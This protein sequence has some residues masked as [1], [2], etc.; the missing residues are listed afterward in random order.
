M[1]R[2]LS[3][4]LPV[5]TARRREDFFVSSANQRAVA[6]IDTW[7]DW[8]SGKIVLAGPPGSGKTHL[9]HIWADM[10]EG[11]IVAA[12]DLSSADIST[13]AAT[14]VAVEDC[15]SIAGD[16]DAERALF[17]LHNLTL[18]EGNPILFTARTA[19]T[20]WS[21]VLPDLASRMQATT[22]VMLEPPDDALLTAVLAK[23]FDDRQITPAPAVLSYLVRRIERSFDAAR[24]AVEKLDRASL[25][26]SRAITRPMAAEVLDN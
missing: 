2:Q 21:L 15:T 13:L 19:P 4:E 25:E 22:T 7:R 26:Q 24:A 3:F 1:S 12:T 10:A 18:A 20:H 8:P 16:A 9:S 14:P 23:L 6:L 11:R 5:R 17:H